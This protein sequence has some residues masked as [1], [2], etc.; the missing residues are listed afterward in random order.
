MKMKKLDDF[1]L[2]VN[3]IPEDFCRDSVEKFDLFPW[4]RGSWFSY[5]LEET[6]EEDFLVDTSTREGSKYDSTFG[7]TEFQENLKPFLSNAIEQYSKQIEGFTDSVQMCSFGKINRYR[8]G[9]EI[10][11]HRDHIHAL[12]DGVLKGVPIL[13]LVGVLNDDFSGGEFI[14]WDDYKIELNC[15][16]VVMFPSNFMYPHKVT[17]VLTGTR[18]SVVSWAW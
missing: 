4:R 16:D 14:F 5:N 9:Q 6:S 10:E 11:E 1:I 15:G 7:N 3:C 18:Y 2:K 17:P 8:I 13:S 12:F